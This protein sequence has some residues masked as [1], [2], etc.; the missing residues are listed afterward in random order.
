[1]IGLRLLL[2]ILEAGFFPGSI[3]LIATWFT[4]YELQKR[5]AVFYMCGCIASGGSGIL[6]YGLQQMVC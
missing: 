5:Y 6:A 3:Y 2:G 1:M 4:R